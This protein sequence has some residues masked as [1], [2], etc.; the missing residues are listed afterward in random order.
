M[1]GLQ[2]GDSILAR[3]LQHEQPSAKGHHHTGSEPD[4]SYR[5]YL[6]NLDVGPSGYVSQ[7]VVEPPGR[8]LTTTLKRDNTLVSF[9]LVA[10]IEWSAADEDLI[11]LRVR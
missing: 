3:S 7:T 1:D 9:N 6:T 5:V 10:S 8:Q 2:A 4:W 11:R